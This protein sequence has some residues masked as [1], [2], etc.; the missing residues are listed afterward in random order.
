[1]ICIYCYPIT[2]YTFQSITNVRFV[3]RLL[4]IFYR[5]K[6]FKKFAKYFQFRNKNGRFYLSD[7]CDNYGKLPYGISAKKWNMKVYMVLYIPNLTIKTLNRSIVLWNCHLLI[8]VYQV[9]CI[10][11]TIVDECNFVYTFWM[12]LV[13]KVTE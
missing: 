4:W 5:K 6:T 3:L 8:W 2:T 10:P 13:I 11:K 12:K 1:M 7:K 9:C